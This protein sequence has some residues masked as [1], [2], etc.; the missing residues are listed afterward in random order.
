M[1]TFFTG[2]YRLTPN[3]LIDLAGLGCAL[4]YGLLAFYAQHGGPSL[5]IFFAIAY[6][7]TPFRIWFDFHGI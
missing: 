7:G 1:L 4:G 5:S 3:H 2:K 6:M